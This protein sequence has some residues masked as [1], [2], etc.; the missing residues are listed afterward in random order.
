MNL[1]NKITI[2]RIFLVP[3]FVS[4]LLTDFP[5]SNL[6][7]AVVFVLA[8]STDT[9]DGYV[10]RKRNEVTSFGKFIDPLADKI[11]VTSALIILVEMG[12]LSS[13]IAIIIITREFVITGFRML[14]ASEGV[15]IAASGW[16]KLKTI[17]QIIAIVAII[18]DNFPFSRIGFPF[19]KISLALAVA[20]TII[21][22]W[23][24]IHKN[25]NLLRKR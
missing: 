7:A 8:A 5:Y 9:V 20:V 6:V 17:L 14:A 2:F 12:K 4:L 15:I 23:D 3:F 1:A 18:L 16:G 19:D 21:S 11:L 24:Y 25:I 13:I 22:G 10:A